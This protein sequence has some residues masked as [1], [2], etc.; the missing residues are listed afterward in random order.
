MSQRF[1]IENSIMRLIIFFLIS[2]GYQLPSQ[3]PTTGT[4]GT[5]FYLAERRVRAEAISA[6]FF[7]ASAVA[8]HEP[9]MPTLPLPA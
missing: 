6:P 4:W 3:V 2:V 9:A 5:Q 7:R 8:F 1:F